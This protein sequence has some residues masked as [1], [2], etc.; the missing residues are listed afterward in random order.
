MREPLR[1][2]APRRDRSQ[3][4]VKQDER[5]T[6]AAADVDPFVFESVARG[7]DERHDESIS[8]C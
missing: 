4:L 5:R 7:G 6:I 1:K 8:A 2:V 3:P